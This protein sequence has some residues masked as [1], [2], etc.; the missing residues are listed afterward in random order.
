[1]KVPPN[2][3]NPKLPDESYYP[4]V[5]NVNF[6]KIPVFFNDLVKAK[7][8]LLKQALNTGNS[9]PQP[10]QESPTFPKSPARNPYN[11]KSGFGP[12]VENELGQSGL[13]KLVNVPKETTPITTPI[14]SS[15]VFLDLNEA[16]SL[17]PEG[18]EMRS[19]SSKIVKFVP[20][21]KKQLPVQSDYN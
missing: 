10:I 9:Y 2:L 1:M 19:E 14:H 17:A 4:D 3:A 5:A 18:R 7:K 15:K 11:T 16:F 21:K 6:G 13:S 12:V 20:W 8:N